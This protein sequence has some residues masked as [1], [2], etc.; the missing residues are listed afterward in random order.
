MIFVDLGQYI[1]L[2]NDYLSLV[3]MVS[4]TN[5]AAQP[6]KIARGFLD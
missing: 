3:D 2:S 6:Q 4:D 5:W 1:K